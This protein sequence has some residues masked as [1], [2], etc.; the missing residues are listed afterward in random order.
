MIM[1]VSPNAASATSPMPTVNMWVRP[2]AH[3]RNEMAM[4][5][6][7]RTG[8]EDRLRAKTD[9]LEMIPKDKQGHDVDPIR[10]TRTGAGTGSVPP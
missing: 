2:H 1:L 4:P 5:D 9:D 7:I 3:E 8:N 6:A 10:S